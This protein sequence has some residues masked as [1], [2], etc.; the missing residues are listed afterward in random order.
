MILYVILLSLAIWGIAAL[1]TDG[2]VLEK[3]G[4]KLIGDKKDPVA[5]ANSSWLNRKWHKPIFTCPVC[6]PSVWGL[7]ASIVFDLSV[8]DALVLII[9]TCGL[10]FIVTKH[11][12]K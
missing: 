9:T 10:N 8:I 12:D 6:M 2:M 4:D 1:F 7:I 11:L 3:L 5:Y